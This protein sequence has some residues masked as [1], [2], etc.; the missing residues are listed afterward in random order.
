MED[1]KRTSAIH[2]ATY[3]S[4]PSLASNASLR[5]HGPPTGVATKTTAGVS[6]T[7]TAAGPTSTMDGSPSTPARVPFYRTRW[8]IIAQFIFSLIGFAMIFILLWPVVRAVV[9]L[10][11]NKATLD[12]QVLEVSS[13]TNNSFGL[14][15]MGNVAHTSSVPATIRF[16]EPIKVAWVYNGNVTQLGTIQL[17]P[18]K[19]RHFR[20]TLN[21]TTTFNITDTLAFARFSQYLIT[22]SNFTW[23]LHS[24]NLRVNAVKFPV[25]KGISFNK[26]ITLN[27]LNSFNSAV[28]LK[29]LQLPSDNP[30]GGI[31]FIAVTEL[32]NRSPFILDLET[33][34]FQLSYQNVFLGVG[35][36]NNV[37]LVN[38][39]NSLSLNGY[40]VRH[41]NPQELT[42]VSTLFTNYINGD[43]SLVIATGQSALRED[44][45]SISWL[46]S[47]LQALQLN[48]P[49]KPTTAVNPINSITFGELSLVFDA[50]NPW[51]P[52]AHSDSV[53]ASMKLPFGFNIS[54]GEVR[55]ILSITENGTAVA[56]L[57]TPLGASRSSI[58]VLGPT[59][60]KGTINITIA[61]T[62]LSISEEQHSS[63]SSFDAELTNSRT[64]EFSL[65]G[66]STAI[67]NTSLGT[68]TLDPIK[69]NASTSL[70]GLNGLRGLVVINS[71]DIVG[72]STDSISLA[73]HVNIF[74]PSN[75]KLY[76]GDLTLHL[77][78]DGV[79]LGNT[80]MH[81]L[82][83]DIGNNSITASSTFNPDRSPQGQQT[84]NDFISHRDIPLTIS[85]F[86]GSTNIA[87]LAKAIDALNINVTLPGSKANLLGAASLTVLPTTGENNIS[88]VQVTLNNPFSV[89]LHITY[90][91]STI[92]AF[93]I[94][95]GTIDTAIDFRVPKKS[96]IQSPVLY[97]DMNLDPSS[98]FTLTRRLAV[99]AGLNVAPLDAVV[100]LGGCQYRSLINGSVS[101]RQSN[102]FNG[103]DLP[104]F[105]QTAFKHLKT[106]V[107]LTTMLT[108]G[109]HQTTL[110]FSQ[111]G[112][113]TATDASLD[114]ILPLL[115]RPIIQR[116][117]SGSTLNIASVLIT[118]PQQY[119]FDAQLKGNI[120]N[121]G[122]FDASISFPSGLTVSW[123]G[124]SLG[125]IRMNKVHVAGD[126]GATIN[127]NS[128]FTVAEVAHLTDFTKA[129][130]TERSFDWVINGNNLTVTALGISVSN[131]SLSAKQVTMQGFNGLEGG[132]QIESFDLPND[133]PAG[134]IHLT[135]QTKIH[136]PSQVGIQLRSISFNTFV[137]DIRIASV[138][139]VGQ[140]AFTPGS[141]TSLSLAGRLLPQQS[142]AGLST[143]STVFNNFLHGMDSNIT[144][145]G[146]GT[147]PTEVTW[148]NDGV[149]VL[150]IKSVLPN[151][152]PLNIIDAIDINQMTLMVTPPTAYDPST[153][154]NSTDA[155]FQM[156]FGFPLDIMALEQTLT[157]GFQGSSI[158][159][160]KIPKGPSVTDV[161][162][163]IIHLQFTDIPFSVFD[164]Q[165]PSFNQFLASTT[166]EKQEQL[167]LSGST[168]AD[169]LTA[170]GLLSL[171]NIS[172]VVN[173]EIYGLQG[174]ATAP[175]TIGQLDVNH[176]Y[177]DCLLIKVSS[178]LLNPS[179]L[180]IGTGT[181]SF[182][183]QFEG[184]T[185]GSANLDDLIIVP[186]NATYPIDVLYAPQ[187]DA[188]SAGRALLQNYLQGVDSEAMIIGKCDSTPVES[189]KQALS[190]IRLSTTIPALKQNLIK[191]A[192][193]TFPIDIVST[194]LASAA[195]T[196]VN[197][198]TASIN[199]LDIVSTVTYH[200]LT[201]GV[202][203]DDISLNP[204]LANGH[205]SSTSPVLPMKFNL[206]PLTIIELITIEAKV[207]N[208][209]LGPLM[210]LFEFVIRNP[211]SHLPIVASVDTSPPTCIS[212][213]QFDFS[214]T[215]LNT[216][217]GLS[218]DLGIQTSFKLDD[219]ATDLAFEQRA[220]T[221]NIDHTVLY[222]VGPVAASI[223]QHLV[224][225]AVLSF[226]S[227][228]ITNISN[229]GFD[230][231]LVG[232]LT[233]IGPLDA[234]IT[235]TEP[236]SV[237][238]HG[239]DIAQI[240]LDPICAAANRGVPDYRAM[241][242]L[243]INDDTQFTAFAT[244]LLHN[245]SF[246]WIISTRKLR[247][248]A[249]GTTFDDVSLSK[250]VLFKAFNNLPGVSI[251]NFNLPS[252]D[253]AGGIHIEADVNIPS[254]AQLGI[255][256]GVVNFQSFYGQ[257]FIGPLTAKNLL[258]SPRSSTISHLS[259]RI[260]PQSGTDLTNVG[261]LFSNFLS[262]KSVPLLVKGDNVTPAG[263][264]EPV[265]WLSNAFK[266]V[267]LPVTLPGRQFNIIQSIEI[268]DLSITMLSQGQA[269]APP[270]SSNNTLA[271]YRNPFGFA[272]QITRS[273]ERI[274]M[275][276]H[277]TRIAQLNIPQMPVDSG[278]SHGNLADIHISFKNEPIT[279]L[280]NEAFQQLLASITLQ[281][282]VSLELRGSADVLA[283][284]SIGNVPISDIPFDLTS[285]LKGINAFG[286]VAS[287]NN[288]F[289]AGS[290]GQG[291]NEYIIAPLMTSLGNPSNVSLMTNDIALPVAYEGVSIGRAVI[292]SFD[293]QPGSNIIATEF[294][295][296]PSNPNDTIAQSFLTRFIQTQDGI[297][298]TIHGDSQSS[299]YGSLQ[300]VLSGLHILTS[301]QGLNHPN[302][303]VHINVHLTLATLATNQ[304]S[305]DID[306]YNPLGAEIVIDLIQADASVGG[307]T[308]AEFTQPF[309]KFVV[310]PGATVNSGVF[311]HVLLTQ[312]WENSLS[313]IPLSYLDITAANTVQIGGA[314]GYHIPW[315]KIEQK[316]VPTTYTLQGINL[317]ELST[318][319]ASLDTK[320]SGKSA[321]TVIP[322]SSGQIGI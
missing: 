79:V 13:P 195:F 284:T 282:I 190:Q 27:G 289:V 142:S 28:I 35:T 7:S 310:P 124:Q 17:R 31:N 169:A 71:V 292:N 319:P 203:N 275:A 254:L 69:V 145:E 241:A 24:H 267:E 49:F 58:S 43:E 197:P 309:S 46:S 210:Q 215:I 258:F 303:V 277:G 52:I 176:G 186:G 66:N 5:G 212:G 196:L 240:T 164:D 181:V 129:L 36:A 62:S 9:Q 242:K 219:F 114:L 225:D 276:S 288:V 185:I 247:L 278:V 268:S 224:D 109:S 273:G 167:Q 207:K 33:I 148:L 100:K 120:S 2:N 149:K 20:G 75:L 265:T 25:A 6:G 96:S 86:S 198:F 320:T 39:I 295:Y 119:S 200:G 127:A 233:N 77:L 287:L 171:Q 246:E 192:S 64:V 3:G 308:Y 84:L 32:I 321:V 103:F 299:P 315:L 137:D 16:M 8:F 226:S 213:Q 150:K 209:E 105:A 106:D 151:Q 123:E 74:N 23:L 266:T 111:L 251:S 255:E 216:L 177:P 264:S 280:N 10:I 237:S 113:P 18:L 159:Q 259:G 269:F 72:G 257:T 81:N 294:R 304:V 270:A 153:S 172:F 68:I 318:T 221:V 189:L 204:I 298:L 139:S 193:L 59:D 47:G 188:D 40:L 91:K 122:P 208:I 202:I 14:S 235:F 252:D 89:D 238:W 121:A 179:M 152:G 99:E 160:L 182:S 307:Q 228:E 263:A 48:V 44:G 147:A 157:V 54:V 236:L 205:S 19:T 94:P 249:L 260:V 316:H 30:A 21:Q 133:D 222:L 110:E 93:G 199:M 218:V 155:T 80:V 97:L 34:V 118:N 262:G 135:L 180:T 154:S 1:S 92:S 245:A 178:T 306:L 194:G 29:D 117:V 88:H 214:G 101:R 211:S 261:Q 128:L 253:P 191:S 67:A 55:N 87:S 239:Q 291:G 50:H 131:I 322:S 165:H 250:T 187:G 274:T 300:L 220:V 90:I 141:T 76:L 78:R 156:P 183:L 161:Q 98:L 313:I 22:S 42:V 65:V 290:G 163:R 104:A 130:L 112:L 256:L 311:D 41:D 285:Q 312:G 126:V 296:Q 63:F 11:V 45:T 244:F 12:V 60:T 281:G 61:N 168:N 38:G 314:T 146:A 174:L 73:I 230:L 283:K 115:A 297:P 53:T 293:L 317:D 136:N 271:Q 162:K 243:T 279:S 305:V 143:V 125:S 15:I 56:G 173:T 217:S 4:T 158:A 108:I 166:V 223:A 140:V 132:V 134:G 82:F 227:A 26:E 234:L 175:L 138:Q 201:L 301:L 286:H 302:L 272:L 144:V 231:F 229:N 102:L 70:K 57:S 116:I 107:Q 51:S 85:G 95:L 37:K 206:D 170:V 83:L 248:T 232:S 184:Q